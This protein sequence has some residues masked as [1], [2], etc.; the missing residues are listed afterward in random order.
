MTFIPTTWGF[1]KVGSIA[2]C[3]Y[4]STALIG[5]P[6][7]RSRLHNGSV[8]YFHLRIGWY[9]LIQ[10]S[11]GEVCGAVV[12]LHSG[13]HMVL[14]EAMA[15]Q[16]MQRSGYGRWWISQVTVYPALGVRVLDLLY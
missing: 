16:S 7:W 12:R 4:P 8:F 3:K 10:I 15:V 5:R 9:Q 1:M 2:D 11:L 6:P 14:S 13:V